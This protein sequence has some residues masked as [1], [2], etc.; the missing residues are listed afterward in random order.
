MQDHP[1]LVS[2]LK[3]PKVYFG[4]LALIFLGWGQRL[5]I[6][7]EIS[8]GLQL[9]TLGI[10]F[11]GLTFF[12]RNLAF[13]K[14]RW[15]MEFF[16]KAGALIYQVAKTRSLKTEVAN[17]EATLAALEDQKQVVQEKKSAFG[18]P[19]KI[20]LVELNLPKLVLIIVGILLLVFSQVLLIYKQ[21]ISMVFIM[22]F[23][24]FFLYIAIRNEKKFVRLGLLGDWI[25]CAFIGLPGLALI[26]IGNLILIKHVFL[27]GH[28]EIIGI[29]CNTIG[30]LF[31]LALMPN[32]FCDSGAM[33]DHPPPRALYILI[34]FWTT[35]P[36]L[37]AKRSCC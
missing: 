31:I 18:L 8:A 13:L 15:L 30:I 7:S 9:T 22:L 29:T 23:S 19:D 17:Q 11:V 32:H 4:L 12:V 5:I 37:W 1:K 3:S 26:L 2:T 34:R 35:S 20:A 33:G 24:I 21:S 16:K 36:S 25:R 27:N 6:Q 14:V 10:L 28:K